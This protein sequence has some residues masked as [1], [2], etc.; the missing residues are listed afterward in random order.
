MNDVE[1]VTVLLADDHGPVRQGL[2]TLLDKD[3]VIQVVGEAHNGQ[4]AVELAKRLRPKVILMDISMPLINGL[5]ATRIILAEQPSAR[6]IILSAQVDEEYVNRAKAVGAVGYIAKH[7]AS[8]ILVAAVYEVAMGSTAW[9]PVGSTAPSLEGNLGNGRNPFG[10]VKSEPLTAADSALL[11]L[12][13]EGISKRRMAAIG[14][15]RLATVERRLELLMAKLSI[16]SF[17][18]LAEYAVASGYIENDV[19]VIVV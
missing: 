12:V 5:E 14:C 8:E 2:R 7:K 13:A 15:M 18:K 1:K 3:G 9:Y 17:A 10:K 4:E 16:L 11:K 6:I 19:Q